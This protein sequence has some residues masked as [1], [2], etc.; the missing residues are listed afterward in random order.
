MKKIFLLLT[1]ALSVCMAVVAQGRGAGSEKKGFLIF[2]AGPSFPLGKFNSNNLNDDQSGFART[3]FNLDLQ[4]GYHFIK[5]VGISGS[6]FY[7]RL[8]VDKN[9]FDGGTVS[10][11]HWQYYGIVVGPMLTQA[12]TPKTFIDFSAMSGMISSNSPKLTAGGVV[13]LSEDWAMAVPFKF[14]AGMR[15]QFARSGFIGLGANYLYADPKYRVSA[16]NEVTS[17]HRRL[18]VA[19]LYGG[20]GFG[21]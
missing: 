6:I 16:L 3:G 10:V 13:I 2:S 17:G 20:I 8:G 4:G 18:S 12:I 7:S 14:S 19:S 11:D 5:N 21:F 15:F 1:A 9:V